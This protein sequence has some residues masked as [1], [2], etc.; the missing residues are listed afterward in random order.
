MEKEIK[1]TYR[2]HKGNEIKCRLWPFGETNIVSAASKS[3]K[4]KVRLSVESF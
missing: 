1:N 3:K 2:T 4:R